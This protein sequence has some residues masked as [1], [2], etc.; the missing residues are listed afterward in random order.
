MREVADRQEECYLVFYLPGEGPCRAVWVVLFK[1]VQHHGGDGCWCVHEGG[2]DREE[3]DR[4]DAFSAVDFGRSG[5]QLDYRDA[6]AD[7]VDEGEEEE[8]YQEVVDDVIPANRT[9]QGLNHGVPHAVVTFC[10][11]QF[12]LLNAGYYRR[13]TCGYLFSGF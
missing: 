4:D 10:F 6:G 8:V 13:D 11:R 5:Q 9:C 7:D 2:G 12:V 1:V 3:Y